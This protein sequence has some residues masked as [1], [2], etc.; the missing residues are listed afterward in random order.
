[1]DEN[2]A[3]PRY[4]VRISAELI[5]ETGGH[6]TCVTRDLSLGGVGVDAERPLAE[7]EPLGVELFVVVDDIEDETSVPLKVQG[8]VAWCRMKNAREFLAGIQFLDVGPD[9]RSYLKQLVDVT[10]A[11]RLPSP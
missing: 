11:G 3:H 9:E 8:R 4:E 7:G 1:M 6:L 5:F 10:A 2:R